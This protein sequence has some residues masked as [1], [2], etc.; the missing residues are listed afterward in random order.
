MNSHNDDDDDD[1]RMPLAELPL[2]PE[3]AACVYTPT[4]AG[5]PMIAH[6]LVHTF[7][8][9][10][11]WANASL[12]A[13]RRAV[14]EARA[15][16]DWCAVVFL[17]ERPYRAETANELWQDAEGFDSAE[18]ARLWREV[19]VDSE[20]INQNLA[21]WGNVFIETTGADWMDDDERMALAAL[22]ETLTVYRGECADGG[23]SWT[24]SEKVARF[25]ANRGVNESTGNVYR[26]KIRRDDVF[27]YLLSR[28]EN[29]ILAMP[30]KVT[31][32]RNIT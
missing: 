14:N 12:R 6:P 21:L 4:G 30:G 25:F 2:G 11:A 24:T 28:N 17:H 27:A 1:E 9:I 18:W 19:W 3:L 10:P 15:A 32:T 26:G 20:N 22:P 8:T 31:D 7:L 23:W 5:L 16:Q 29:E 13:K